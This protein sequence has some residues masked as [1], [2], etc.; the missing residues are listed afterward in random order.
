MRIDIKNGIEGV[1]CWNRGAVTAYAAAVNEKEEQLSRDNPDL[2][3][4]P[5]QVKC[6]GC[7]VQEYDYGI[8]CSAEVTRTRFVVEGEVEPR[9][10]DA[11]ASLREV[12][13]L[14]AIKPGSEGS[15]PT[16]AA[17]LASWVVRD[18]S[19]E[20]APRSGRRGLFGRG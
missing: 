3:L 12:P 10:A 2:V 11:A 9:A 8:R 5:G 16:D 7:V 15:D 13:G 20:H 17:P 1:A 19:A 14:Q 4:R 18:K 6:Y